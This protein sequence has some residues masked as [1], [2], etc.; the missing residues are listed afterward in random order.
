M[1]NSSP[2]S[3][4]APTAIARFFDFTGLKTDLKTE[5]IAGT[6]T[7]ITMAYILVVNPD[8]LSNAI[9]LQESGDLFGELVVATGI[10]AAIATLI[11]GI[12]AKYPIDRKSVV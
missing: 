5:V 6:T 1:N 9:F 11:M 8:I 3:I 7:F 12:V 10:S 2:D 4:P